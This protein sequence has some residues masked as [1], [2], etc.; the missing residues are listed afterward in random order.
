M[1]LLHRVLRSFGPSVA[2]PSAQEILRAS[3]GAG[4]GLVAI[5]TIARMIQ[6]A[7][8]SDLWLIAPLGATAFLAFAV[9][10]SPL[11]QPWSAIVGNT[12]SALIGIAVVL[13]VPQP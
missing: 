4:I 9:P 2:R 3:V 5:G 12:V 11:A 1:T 7:S 10:N 13:S 8:G 6:P